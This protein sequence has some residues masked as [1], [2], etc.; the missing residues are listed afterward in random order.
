MSRLFLSRDIKDGHARLDILSGAAG[1]P[2]KS[3][4]PAPALTKEKKV[5]DKLR[6]ELNTY[7][8]IDGA[9][10]MEGGDIVL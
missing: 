10:W 3:L 2:G 9:A 1:A 4:V 6:E 5:V 8:K 7:T